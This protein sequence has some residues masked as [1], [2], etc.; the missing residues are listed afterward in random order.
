MEKPTATSGV[1]QNGRLVYEQDG[2]RVTATVDSPSWYAWL[3]TATTFTFTCEEGTF[4]AHKARAGNQRGSWYWRAYRRQHGR[5]SRCYLGIS[6]NLTLP[7]LCEAARRLAARSEGTPTRQEASGQGHVSRT[8]TSSDVLTPVLILNTKC[9]LPRLPVQHVPRAHL[10]ALLEKGAAGP[11]T[12]VSAPVGSGKTT[13]LTEWARTTQMPVAWLSL[14]AADSDPARF[15]AYLLA[16]LRTLDERI[17]RE[18][19]KQLDTPSALNLQAAL[20]SL[21][22]DLTHHLTTDAVLVL[23]DYHVLESEVAHTPLLFLLEHLPE[24]LHLVLG[25]RVDPPFPLARL[26][27]RGQL[28]EIR[29]GTLRFA[30]TEMK[31]FLHEMELE[32]AEDELSSLQERTEGWIAGVQL[33]ALALQGHH[34]PT[35]FLRE[36]RGNHRFILEY[37]SEEI[38]ARQAPQVRAFLLQT[39]ILERLSGSLCDTV[40]GKTGSQTILEELRKANLFVSAL[41]ETGAWY[42]YHTLFAEGLRHLLVQQE[43]ALFPELCVRASAWY[44]AREMLFE[45]CEYALQARDVPRAVPL[46]ERQVHEL[47]TGHVEF[48]A[49]RRWLDQLPPDVIASRPLLGVASTW[50]LFA[51]DDASERLEQMIAQLQQDF[52]EHAAETDLAGWA[53]ARVYLNFTLSMHALSKNDAGRAMELARQTLQALPEEATYLRHLASLSMSLTQGTLH[54]LRGDFA[55]AERIFIEA[56]T[57]TQAMDYPLLH[58]TATPILVEMYEAQGELHKIARLFQQPLQVLHSTKEVPPEL[59]VWISMAYAKLLREWNRLDE[60]E[61]AIK[62]ALATG[63]RIQFKDLSLSCRLIQ[64]GIMQARGRYEEAL[65]LLCEIEKELPGK[66]LAVLTVL[67]RTRLLLI[68]GKEDEALLW[69]RE[70]GLSY[71]D[72]LPELPDEILFAQYMTLARVH[73]ALGLRS[74]GE[75]HLTQALALLECFSARYEPAGFTG[76]V[77]EILALTSLA[78]QAQGETQSALAT[79]RRAVSLAEPA[80]Y[81]RVFADEGEQMA[82]LLARLSFQK[83]ATAA[84]LRTLLEATSPGSA[85]D[86]KEEARRKLPVVDMLLPELLSAREMEVLA[87]LSTGAS[88]RDIAARLVITPNTAKRHVKHILA[89]LAATNRTQAVTRARELHLL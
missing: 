39:S 75:A 40:T 2:Q 11:L 42:R 19:E 69:L 22:N 44:E 41:D 63:R 47:F 68:Q 78:L 51:D 77:I 17:G 13:L 59:A 84:Y 35:A 55:A 23:D 57:L 14:E 65:Q 67:A 83:P 6:A 73:I 79:L 31:T 89:K 82:R 58:M 52:Q 62:L 54:R 27:A 26:R 60:A 20:S 33:A 28:S 46:I 64:H 88:N 56:G 16:A 36:F 10:V 43:P 9:A 7:C 45:A 37:L 53:E 18:A 15:L 70:S 30:T 3:E 29:T 12:L 21:V 34:D 4:T 81:V 5:L 1:V 85:K 80:G 74:P 76:R 25:T 50:I 87:E 24:R 72:P 61:N 32:L 48:A 86:G 71:D 38:L 8:T 66:Q 49:L